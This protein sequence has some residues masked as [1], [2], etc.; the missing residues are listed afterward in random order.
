[1]KKCDKLNKFVNVSSYTI[2]KIAS[3]AIFHAKH[4]RA[5]V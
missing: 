1:M 3:L 4:I 5:Q 2:S